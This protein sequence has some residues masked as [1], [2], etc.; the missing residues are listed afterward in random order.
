M[1]TTPDPAP[2]T[3]RSRRSDS[4]SAS[5]SGA[6]QAAEATPAAPAPEPVRPL[7]RKEAR[8]ARAQA[9]IEANAVAEASAGPTTGITPTVSRAAAEGTSPSVT[10]PS[11][12]SFGPAAGPT[13]AEVDAF[14]EALAAF[15]GATTPAAPAHATVGAEWTRAATDHAASATH[16]PRRARRGVARRL[17]AASFS[18]GVMGAVGL[19][20]LSTAAPAE[21]IAAAVSER[22]STSIQATESITAEARGDVQ[23][24]VAPSDVAVDSSREGQSY[25]AQSIADVASSAGISKHTDFFVNDT[26][27]SIQWP[28]AV[29]VSITDSWGPRWGSFHHGIDFIPGVGAEIQAIADGTV[30]IATESG[31]AYGV[32]VVIDHEIDG[33]RVSSLYAHMLNGSIK[34][35]PGQHVTVGTPL[36]NT[37]D[38]GLSYGP[39]THFEIEVDGTRINPLPWLRENTGRTF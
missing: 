19:L 9:V 12:S 6:E 25:A 31:G 2:A 38:T 30:R 14:A 7:T 5:P 27:A 39:H 4:L 37:G 34:V 10:L 29:G 15:G 33:R 26:D 22:S 20:A 32:Y 1:Q 35:Q 13:R 17:V 8:A 18:V 28:F 11:A 16:A 36:G 21:A 3:R 24:F 23:A